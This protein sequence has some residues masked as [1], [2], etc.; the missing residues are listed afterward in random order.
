M[1]VNHILKCFLRFLQAKEDYTH[2]LQ[3]PIQ[4]A[5]KGSRDYVST[6]QTQWQLEIPSLLFI[7]ASLSFYY[8]QDRL[9]LPQVFLSAE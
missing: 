9:S 2:S 8:S 5:A 4:A 3:G 6:A 1:D 7:V